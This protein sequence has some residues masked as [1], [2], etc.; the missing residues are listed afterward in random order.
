MPPA[1]LNPPW[2]TADKGFL[3]SSAGA[4]RLVP[5]IPEGAGTDAVIGGTL[6][7]TVPGGAG[8]LPGPIGGGVEPAA[9]PILCRRDFRSIFGFCCSAIVRAATVRAPALAC[10]RERPAGDT[11]DQGHDQGCEP[12]PTEV[13]AHVVVRRFLRPFV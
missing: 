12:G 1:G 9:G 2:A 8:T 13:Y 11:A 4:G 3:G 5:G 7:A 6:R 10:Q